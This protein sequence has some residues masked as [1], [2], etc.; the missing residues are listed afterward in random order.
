MFTKPRIFVAVA[1]IYSC[2]LS[3]SLAVDL[4]QPR[5]PVATILAY[6]AVGRA[7]KITHILHAAVYFTPSAV[8]SSVTSCHFKTECPDT[9]HSVDGSERRPD[10]PCHWYHCE[11]G[12]KG[13]EDVRSGVRIILDD[14]YSWRFDQDRSTG[15]WGHLGRHRPQ[16]IPT[17][18]CAIQGQ[19]PVGHGN[20]KC[21]QS[22]Y[23]LARAPRTQISC[24]EV[25][26]A[27]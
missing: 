23:L 24:L 15:F 13:S 3:I 22:R 12:E 6:Q 8:I 4:S 16:S 9:A 11:A 26:Q 18:L 19:L 1:L 10:V 25:H 7:M 14:C 27:Q 17:L 20:V 21:P 2:A 5:M